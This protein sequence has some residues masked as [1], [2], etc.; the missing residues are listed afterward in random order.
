MHDTIIHIIFNEGDKNKAPYSK[1]GISLF[2]RVNDDR[3]CDDYPE[4]YELRDPGVLPC[5]CI[6]NRK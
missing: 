5:N 4:I 2:N 6:N 3:T 1:Y